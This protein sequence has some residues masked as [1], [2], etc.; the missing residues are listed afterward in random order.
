MENRFE[1]TY[2]SKANN[3]LIYLANKCIKLILNELVMVTF[4]GGQNRGKKE[5]SLIFI[6]TPCFMDSTSETGKY[7]IC[8]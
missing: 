8:L 7:F 5:R 1:Y 4:Q 3:K 2:K 6:N